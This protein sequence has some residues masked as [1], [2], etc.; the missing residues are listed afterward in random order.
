MGGTARSAAATVSAVAC[1]AAALAAVAGCTRGAGDSTR[2]AGEA[3]VVGVV[4]GDTIDVDI[5][6]SVERVRM[7][8]I[9]TPESVRPDSPVECFG[10]EA[11]A[12]TGELLPAGSIVRL[13]RDIEARD[14]Y[15]R[16]LAYV[17]RAGDAMF[18]NLELVRGGYA[19]PFPFPPNVTFADDFV[20]AARDAQAAHLGLWAACGG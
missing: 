10:P 6:G 19:V 3:L 13:V 17:Y 11:S 4:D 1:A 12:R 18:V 9:D 5:A 16:L 20:A 14:D 2:P 7:I 8:G 15:G